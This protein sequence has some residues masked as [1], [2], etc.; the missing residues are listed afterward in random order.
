[1]WL[2]VYVEERMGKREWDEGGM[3]S[4]MSRVDEG[5]HL[6][7]RAAPIWGH[8]LSGSVLSMHDVSGLITRH[9]CSARPWVYLH[10]TGMYFELAAEIRIVS[11]CNL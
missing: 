10:R 7:G 3:E 2:E 1:M 4:R 6:D 8:S 5:L 9:D 11:S